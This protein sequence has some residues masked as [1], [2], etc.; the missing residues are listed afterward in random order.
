MSTSIQVFLS[1]LCTH[2]CLLSMLYV[3]PSFNYTVTSILLILQFPLFLCSFVFLML[4]Y[5]QFTVYFLC[6]VAASHSMKCSICKVYPI[7]GL[8]YQCLDCLQYNLCQTCF[9]L[10]RVTK[11]H[12][13]KHPVQE[14]CYEACVT[15]WLWM[16]KGNT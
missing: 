6:S 1:K 7:V 10:G 8:R 13:L 2:L 9:F 15:T 11:K 12:K 14:H 5:L 16:F 4:K 3:C